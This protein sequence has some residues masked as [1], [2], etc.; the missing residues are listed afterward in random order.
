MLLTDRHYNWL[1]FFFFKQWC[2]CEDD[3]FLCQITQGFSP[4]LHDCSNGWLSVVC[5]SLAYL[6]VFSQQ[7]LRYNCVFLD[8]MLKTIVLKWNSCED[9]S[10]IVK[11]WCCHHFSRYPYVRGLTLLLHLIGLMSQF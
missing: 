6:F 11:N 2:A 4:K 9:V 7:I 3:K 1:L 10:L 5:H 8:G